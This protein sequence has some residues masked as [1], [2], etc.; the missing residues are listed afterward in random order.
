MN[1]PKLAVERPVFMSCVVILL[2]VLGVMA[3]STMAVD[4]F[5][6]VSFPFVIVTTPY[7]G[8]S[9]EEIETQVSKPMEDEF[10]TIQGVKKVTSNNQEGYS[11][12]M[13][14]F[15]MDADVKDSEQQVKDHLSFVRTT[16]P[17]DIDE[18]IV[19]RLDP[20]ALPVAQLSLSS[21]LPPAQ[22]YDLADQV[23]KPQLAQVE[24]VGVINIQ[25]GRK[26][27][28]QVQLDRGLLNRFH[29]SASQV[30]T[31]I[32]MNGM[33]VP[34]GKVQ[35][36]GRDLLFRSVGQYEDLDRLRQTSVNFM[37]S[38]VSVPVERLGKVVDTVEDAQGYSFI[39]GQSALIIQI[40]KQSKANTVAVVDALTKRIS[41]INESLKGRPG[42]PRLDMFQ[43]M[44]WYIRMNLQ[45]VKF[46]ILQ[47][48]LL[49][50]LVVFLFLGSFRSTLI[51]ITALPVSLF[52]AFFLMNGVGFTLN[53]MTFLALSLAV[54]LLIDDAIVV[55]ENIW[56]HIEEGT[57]P[58]KA[59][60][61]AAL[62]VAL[63]VV[64]TSSVV[65]AVFMPISFLSGLVGQFFRQFGLT[66]CFAMSI[67]LFEAM[68]MGPLLSAFW[69]KKRGKG[70]SLIDYLDHLFA[71]FLAKFGRFQDFLQ[72]VYSKV[73][74]A[75]LKHRFLVILGAV[76][77]FLCSLGLLPL[78]K[79][80]FKPSAD[81]GQF[82]VYL[83]ADPATSLETMRDKTL[84][85]EKLVRKH[86]E[87]ALVA[88]S[89]GGST[90]TGADQGSNKSNLYIL[91]KPADQRHIDTAGLKEILR[92]ELEPYTKELSPQVAD[93][94]PIMNQAPFTLNLIGED[95][96]VLAP[97][98]LQVVEKVKSIPGLADVQSTF[99][100]G[101]PEFQ[102]KLDPVKLKNL[103]VSGLEAGGELRTQ[104]E[105]ATPAKFRQGGLDYFIR[106]R[107]Q[108][109]QRNLQKEFP[110]VLV[111]NQNGNLVRLSDIADPVTTEGPS[112][113]DR[114]NRA[115]YIQITG[116]LTPGG[117]LGNVL[118]DGKKILQSMQM[119]K[120]VSYEFVGQAEDFH[121]L[122]V[123]MAIA[124]GLAML[125]T[126]MILASLY[127]SPIFPFAIMLPIPMA[128][129]GA[130]AA[131]YAGG[132]FIP[133]VNLSLFSMI[134]II[135][136]MGLV[137]KNSILLIDYTLQMMRK[138]MPRDEALKAAGR[139]RLRPILMTTFAL[140]A[141]MLPVAMALTE[142]GKFRQSMG[143]AMEGGLISSLVLTL[144]IIPSSFGYVDD[145]RLWIRRISGE[146]EDDLAPKPDHPSVVSTDKPG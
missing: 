77:I 137:T 13:V 75:C 66:V 113:I 53:M 42:S 99:N 104:V 120:G 139:V 76:L 114:E 79:V 94:D 49:T 135:M 74:D 8:A 91:M 131:L 84:E 125:F 18:P 106:V 15:N 30:A 130:L 51:T 70:F 60:V 6:D 3:Y 121:D 146:E 29:I 132:L 138:G 102:A 14:Q 4:L 71:P 67:S 141:G 136:L 11:V 88:D 87:V 65:I 86:P 93:Y 83:M 107:L 89:I 26:R 34:V 52:G 44:A 22:A 61:E 117:S 123:N 68:V 85:I 47:G 97:Y 72:E 108:E 144:I 59:A 9:P 12:V 98:A 111:P 45:D 27:E 92:K 109:D 25:G 145:F 122:L 69:G 95:Y 16:L 41:K 35:V 50:I 100:G 126:Y 54:G 57:E 142:I 63:A 110:K 2:L 73:I 112:E 80:T 81:V 56:R 39:N 38:D 116:Q 43:D 115:R 129:I 124:V 119:P 20:S 31:R 28:I 82:A 62:E 24:G 21:T 105:G 33:N 32:G 140:I 17:K 58:K 36:A 127:E 10:S 134:A 1:L 23:I 55:R 101:K 78:M 118:R 133:Y 5:P 103:G 40:V 48:I 96:S 37:G 128:M 90:A 64:A 7:Q 19:R 46:T 143:I